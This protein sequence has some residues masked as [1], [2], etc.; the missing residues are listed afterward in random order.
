MLKALKLTADL[1]ELRDNMKLLLG[2][3]YTEEISTVR[4]ILRG[5]AREHN[6]NLAEEALSISRRMTKE[7][8]D[9]AMVF[10]ALVDECEASE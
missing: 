4:S 1:I 8:H 9:P 2:S 5:S 10:A 3:K 6:T 7:R